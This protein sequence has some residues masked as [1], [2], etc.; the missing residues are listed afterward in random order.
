LHDGVHRGDDPDSKKGTEKSK[1]GEYWVTIKLTNG[2]D[3]IFLSYFADQTKA[4]R[5]I[6]R[7][8]KGSTMCIFKGQ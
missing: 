6:N 2:T 4:E 5:S 7:L 8:P 1:Q 3:F